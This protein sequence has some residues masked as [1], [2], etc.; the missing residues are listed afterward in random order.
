MIMELTRTNLLN[1]RQQFLHLNYNYLVN[2][3]CRKLI[4]YLEIKKYERD[5]IYVF[6]STKSKF[7]TQ[8]INL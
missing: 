5:D 4:G 1:Y 2:F 7:V 3:D 6:I 8:V